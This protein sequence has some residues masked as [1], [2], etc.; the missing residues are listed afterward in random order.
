M[1]MTR[2]MTTMND[3]YLADISS[4]EDLRTL[5]EDVLERVC[6]EVR[7]FIVRN[8]A[9]T[10]GHF[11]SN[12]GTVE[13]TVALHHVFNTPHDT[14]VWDTGHQAY[15]HKILTGRR[16]VF[17]TLRQFKGVSGFPTPE[18]SIYDVYPV[19]HAGTSISLALGME[20]ARNLRKE[21]THIIAVIGD[22]SMTS[23]LALEALNNAHHARKFLLIL[24][25]NE[26]SISPTIGALARHFSKIVVNPHYLSFKHGVG[27]VLSRLPLVGNALVRALQRLQGG[28]K[29]MLV[30]QN[31]FEQLGFHYIGPIDGHNV[32]E[33]VKILKDCQAEHD[34]PVL[35]HVITRK[36]KGYSPAEDNPEKYHGVTPFNP[37]TICDAPP[38]G[39]DNT[40]TRLIS[41]LLAEHTEKNK[42]IVVVSAAMCDGTGMKEV[43]KKCPEQLVD[44]G[45][46]EQHAVTYAG[47]LAARGFRP[48]V[49]IYS[50]FL[51]RAYDQINHDVCMAQM[52]VVFA[53]DRAGLV[54]G[55]GKT[56][57]GVYDI[58]YLRHL[59]GMS[60]FMPRD[61]TAMRAV[62]D[63]A[64]TLSSPC[65]I[66]YPRCNVPSTDLLPAYAAPHVTTW[67]VLR[68][69]DDMAL[70]AIG[71][72]VSIAWETAGLLAHKG[73]Q[74]SVIDACAIQPL[75]TETLRKYAGSTAALVTLEDHTLTGGF[76]SAVAECLADEGINI[77]LKRIGIPDIFV[78]HGTR[79]ELYTL[80]G[81]QPKELCDTL[82][83]WH[84]SH[85]DAR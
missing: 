78:E 57:H 71:P 41:T 10:G 85:A 76:G 30:P 26:M 15:A 59:P 60:I 6:D 34:M 51:Q 8:V 33:L 50:T 32:T 23:G 69:G 40:Y 1:K 21:D 42:E 31:V 70:I 47:G 84:A 53:V 4:P 52:P 7:E 46:A 63:Y 66:R 62:L 11:A 19:G 79:D 37:D 9:H 73:I 75:D 35:L 18:E 80:L 74:A 54:G 20:K 55:D 39:A 29:H 38:E 44:V 2:A 43:A 13:L 83:Q 82:G 28:I 68:E 12:L 67:D 25:D 17:H 36:G 3:S 61:E 14:I 48:V 77:P 49:A 24:N 45:I 22:G 5:P 72:M 16:D 56:H 58:A 65:A 64:F 81:W 27:N